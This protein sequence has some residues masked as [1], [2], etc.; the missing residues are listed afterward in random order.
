MPFA[1]RA[2]EVARLLQH[3]ADEMLTLGDAQLVVFLNAQ[4]GRR[5]IKRCAKF[6][7][8]PP[9]HQPHAAWAAKRMADIS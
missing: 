7:R 8:I 5:E 4:S 3:G 1:N 2:G 6:V 9:G